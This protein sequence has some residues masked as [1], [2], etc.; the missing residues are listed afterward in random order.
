M[1]PMTLE[2]DISSLSVVAPR[3][4]PVCVPHPGRPWTIA[5]LYALADDENRYELVRGE[6]MMMSP[7][8]PVQGRYAARL[9][10]A[11]SVYVD[12]HDLGEVYTAEPGFILAPEPESVVRAP[13]LAFVSK[14]RIPPAAQQQ[15][16][17]ALAPDLAVEVISPSE[18][19]EDIQIKVQDYLTAGTRLIWLVYPRTRTVLEYQSATRIRQLGHDDNL[20]GGVVIPGFV[21]P[22][23]RLFRDADTQRR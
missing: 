3:A 16:F 1:P 8:S 4:E 18:T 22:L 21:Y 17:W 7:A 20:E 11:L 23:R 13:D 6:L 14:E 10:A 9:G 2:I 12:E 5:D 15:G 19:A